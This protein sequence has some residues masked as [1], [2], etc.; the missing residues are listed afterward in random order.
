MFN[1]NANILGK[2]CR[3]N[4]NLV[5]NTHTHCKEELSDPVQALSLS[6]VSLPAISKWLGQTSGQ[7]FTW[8]SKT[9]V[10]L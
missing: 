7:S 5:L 4:I 2:S 1:S 6:G 9:S 3:P 10:K 8:I